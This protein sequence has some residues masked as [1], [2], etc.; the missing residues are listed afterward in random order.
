MNLLVLPL[1]L[2]T[3]IFSFYI[4]G[5]VFL[6]FTRKEY[7]KLEL[8]LLSWPVGLVSFL[9]ANYVFAWA[10]IPYAALLLP[11]A[12]LM[13][14]AANQK[15]LF[16]WAFPFTI[17]WL[18]VVIIFLGAVA[19]SVL[20]FFSGFLTV[21][22][23]TYYD[24]NRIDGLV[25]LAL[26]K[27][28]MNAFPPLNPSLADV[29]LRGYHY[30]YNFL[31]SRF[32]LFY[33]F[34]PRDLEFR[35][36]PMF[37]SLLF[38]ISFYLFSSLFTKSV[39]AKRFILFFA[40][41]GENAGF[42]YSYLT[43]HS[44]FGDIGFPYGAQ[45]VLDP[46]VV[47]A[48]SLLLTGLFFL[49]DKR[50]NMQTAIVTGLFIGVLSEVKV[51]AGLI[52]IAVLLLFAGYSVWIDRKEWKWYAVIIL[53][54]GFLTVV[55]F[56]PNNYGAGALVW[57]PFLS[58][59]HF[60]SQPLFDNLKWQMLV[61]LYAVH[62][63]Y[64][65]IAEKYVEAIVIF[66]LLI[67]G[68]RSIIVLFVGKL[69]KKSFWKV[70][71]NVLV[72]IL[73]FIAL[74]LGSFF[75]Q[76]VS[77]FDILQF[78]WIGVAII[79]IPSGIAYAFLFKQANVIGKVIVILIIGIFSAI[80]LGI[81]YYNTFF[82]SISDTYTADQV[83][84]FRSV[85][86]IV[87]PDGFIIVIPPYDP[88]NF[89]SVDSLQWYREPLVAAFTGRST[90]YEPAIAY[91]HMYSSLYDLRKQ[92]VFTLA[93]DLEH[94]ATGKAY[95]LLQKIGTRYVVSFTEYSCD[96]WSKESIRKKSADGIYF[97]EFR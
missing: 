46:S 64:L 88:T 23:V 59:N 45:L 47:I 8:F 90:Y 44:L 75:I 50:K 29:S 89:S 56:F 62:N 13:Y 71:Q 28:M 83:R 92:D 80:P 97:Y 81:L 91:Y 57:A 54:S 51:Y 77:V 15:K 82:I 53:W 67:L 79:A 4:P 65:H 70:R 6:S 72:F 10:Q 84:L 22:G 1:F 96:G 55:T 19:F 35:L 68:I 20:T 66:W 63:N 85:G 3:L 33:H 16:A 21:N 41:F 5:M 14:A 74:F 58:Y 37:I 34:L 26:I 43:T 60:I 52:A 32:A 94:C 69:F 24:V 87:P 40:F 42:V 30:F 93:K 48:I 17:D 38:G 76:T 7:S 11:A 39:V 86:A 95:D 49:G 78:F 73:F 12:C 36:F 61:Q 9:L 31:L 27:N 25:H 18:A 2:L